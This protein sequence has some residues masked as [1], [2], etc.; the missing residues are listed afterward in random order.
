[1]YVSSG[2]HGPFSVLLVLLQCLVSLCCVKDHAYVGS[3]L[4]VSSLGTFVCRALRFNYSAVNAALSLHNQLLNHI[5]RLPKSFFDTNPAGRILNRFSRDTE[6]MDSTVAT[7]ALMFCN[8]MATFIAILIVISVATKWFAVA[9]IPITIT[10]MLLQ[11]SSVSQIAVCLCAC[12]CVLVG[13]QV[14]CIVFAVPCTC[15]ETIICLQ[16]KL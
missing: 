16:N 11:V 12:H 4:Q 2:V 10:Y 6:I 3:C 13:M 1:M 7:S 9:I 14:Q 8:C 15:S 5:L